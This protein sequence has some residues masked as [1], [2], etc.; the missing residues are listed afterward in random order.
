M[1]DVS[2]VDAIVKHIDEIPDARSDTPTDVEQRIAAQV[3]PM[4]QDGACVQLGI[5]GVPDIIAGELKDRK[6][7]GVHTEPLSDG[8]ASLIAC[9]AVTNRRKTTDPGKSM[10]SA[11]LRPDR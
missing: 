10:R 7:L 9:G 11:Y 2:K 8:I 5:G 1:V 4:V 3:S 6:D